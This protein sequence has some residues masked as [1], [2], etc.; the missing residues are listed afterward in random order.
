MEQRIETFI[1]AANLLMNFD[2]SK[3]EH[4]KEELNKLKSR[5]DTFQSQ[6]LESRKHI[7]LCVQYFTL[8]NEVTIIIQ[9]LLL[10]IIIYNLCM[11]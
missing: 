6:V 7:D 3:S 4:I 1:N 9:L 2:Q 11:L 8:I 5:W 10:I